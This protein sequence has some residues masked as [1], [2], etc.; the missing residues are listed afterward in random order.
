MLINSSGAWIGFNAGAASFNNSDAQVWMNW[1]GFTSGPTTN[2]SQVIQTTVDQINYLFNLATLPQGQVPGGDT[3]FPAIVIP[4]SSMDLD[5]YQLT[6]IDYDYNND[7]IF[8]ATSV[9]SSVSSILVTY[10]GP[11]WPTGNYRVYYAAA[12]PS[13]TNGSFPYSW[14]GNSKTP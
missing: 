1:S 6:D 9:N 11:S 8:A 10:S 3:L 2:G 5:T 13:N 7:A 12:L 4:V 14:K